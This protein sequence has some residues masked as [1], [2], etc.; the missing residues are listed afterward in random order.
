MSGW[1]FPPWICSDCSLSLTG[2]FFSIGLSVLQVIPPIASGC[3]AGCLFQESMSSKDTAPSPQPSCCCFLLPPPPPLFL[4]FHLFLLPPIPPFLP[5]PPP[6]LVLFC[7]LLSG[8]SFCRLNACLQM[9][10]L[11]QPLTFY[12]PW[13]LYVS[14]FSQYLQY[15]VH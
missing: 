12:F 1:F 5:A 3:A 2:H 4:L 8:R 6:L 15:C 11:N 7:L 10:T 13:H 9:H 14:W